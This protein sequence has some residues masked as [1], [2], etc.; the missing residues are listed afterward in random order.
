MFRVE[1][2]NKSYAKTCKIFELKKNWWALQ[3]DCNIL[4]MVI[5]VGNDT[6]NI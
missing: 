5:G 3:N 6:G 2:Q 1:C 4:S